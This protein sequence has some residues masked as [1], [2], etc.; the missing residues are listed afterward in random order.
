V[1]TALDGVWWSRVNG[2]YQLSAAEEK[3]LHAT[4]EAMLSRAEKTVPA[5]K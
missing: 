1:M 2:L 3:A 5:R 4:L